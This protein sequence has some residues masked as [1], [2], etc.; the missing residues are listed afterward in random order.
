MTPDKNLPNPSASLTS[1][2][3]PVVAGLSPGKSDI[4]AALTAN[5]LS[6]AATPDRPH[7]V[8]AAAASLRT[9][10]MPREL[11]EQIDGINQW[12]KA[13]RREA[14]WESFWFWALKVPVIVATAG[15]GLLAKNDNYNGLAWAGATSAACVLIDGLF[16]PGTLR[17]FHQRAYFELSTIADDLFDQWDAAALRG[18]E[19]HGAIASRLIEEA[20]KRK[21]KVASYLTD[22]EASL[23]KGPARKAGK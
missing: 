15:Y 11:A 7:T 4:P 17:N 18:D 19:A 21:A 9:T 20:R 12:A 3:S 10:T 8:M 13:N 5:V 1:G 14:K 23:G 16:R 2:G 22:A 6:A